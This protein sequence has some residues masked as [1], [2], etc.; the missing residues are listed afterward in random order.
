MYSAGLKS[1]IYG[2][3]TQLEQSILTSFFLEDIYMG[4]LI[5]F[6]DGSVSSLWRIVRP[7]DD[8]EY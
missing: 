6:L 1:W 4:H 3:E 8:F 7:K 2:P 5:V